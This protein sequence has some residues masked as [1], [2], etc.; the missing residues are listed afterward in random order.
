MGL[1]GLFWH[2]KKFFIAQEE[3]EEGHYLFIYYYYF[4]FSPFSFG[5]K[6]CLLFNCM[7]PFC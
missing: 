6:V 3:E 5:V 4:C 7:V 2:S 1:C